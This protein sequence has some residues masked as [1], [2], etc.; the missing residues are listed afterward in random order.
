MT[1]ADPSFP[2]S[3]KQYDAE[4]KVDTLCTLVQRT[5]EQHDFLRERL[6]ALELRE[7][8]CIPTPNLNSAEDQTPAIDNAAKPA[9]GIRL[10]AFEESLNAS[11]P[12]RNASWDSDDAFSIVSSAG[13]TGSW[14]TLSGLSLSEISHI[15][16]LAIPI[17]PSDISNR[18]AYIFDMEVASEYELSVSPGSSGDN[19]ALQADGKGKQSMKDRILVLQRGFARATKFEINRRQVFGVPLHESIQYAYLEN[20]RPTMESG[21]ELSSYIIPIVIGSTGRFIKEKGKYTSVYPCLVAQY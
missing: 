18:D 20:W 2:T 1:I 13:R 10:F 15:A 8:G 21:L 4:D 9:D 12:Y 3:Q 5:L 6:T 19:P 17:Y 7:L 11:R 14:S 16:I